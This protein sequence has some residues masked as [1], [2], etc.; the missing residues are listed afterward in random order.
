MVSLLDY[1]TALASLMGLKDWE[2]QF[3]ETNCDDDTHAEIECVYGQRSAVISV[4]S[5]FDTYSPALERDVLVHELCHA[6]LA[7]HGQM[8]S[9]V[10]RSFLSEEQQKVADIVL[11]N[12]EEWAVD[13]LS[14]A[15]CQYLPTREAV[16]RHA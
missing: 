11:T 4:N 15:L 14:R 9:D 10:L 1:T 5:K 3:S 2:F 7:Q 6:L 16:S 8:T 13:L 12:S